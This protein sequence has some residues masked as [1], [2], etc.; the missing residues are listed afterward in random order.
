MFRLGQQRRLSWMRWRYDENGGLA[1]GAVSVEIIHGSVEHNPEQKSS[2]IY[3]TRELRASVQ[4]GCDLCR[5]PRCLMDYS[6]ERKAEAA[7]FR[8]ILI[9]DY[10]CYRTRLRRPGTHLELNYGSQN[11]YTASRPGVIGAFRG[12]RSS[13]FVYSILRTSIIRIPEPPTAKPKPQME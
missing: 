13:S 5:N 8:R 11:A 1:G 10:I 3:Y 2:R 7:T 4:L 12:P 9:A 6:G